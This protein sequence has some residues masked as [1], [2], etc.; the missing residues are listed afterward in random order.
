MTGVPKLNA[1]FEQMDRNKS[2]GKIALLLREWFRKSKTTGCVSHGEFMGFV[3]ARFIWHSYPGG[4]ILLMFSTKKLNPDI[5]DERESRFRLMM[6]DAEADR[7]SLQ[8]R[9]LPLERGT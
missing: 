3:T 6:G 2:P 4:F 5:S 9:A 8:T 1:D 7:P